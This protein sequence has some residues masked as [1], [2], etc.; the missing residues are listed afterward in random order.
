MGVLR[1]QRHDFDRILSPIAGRNAWT[2]N[3]GAYIKSMLSLPNS[4]KNHNVVLRFRLATDCAVAGTGWYIDSIDINRAAD[5]TPT[6]TATAAGIMIS[7]NVSYCSNPVPGPVPGVTLTITGT[8][9]RVTDSSGNYSFL[10]PP[11]ANITVTPSK[12]PLV[13]GGPGSSGI[14]TADVIAIQKHYL[15][16]TAL[17]GCRLTAADCAAPAGIN[18]VD[19]LA[20]QKFFLQ[21]NGTGNVGQ[22][23]FTPASRFY[24]NVTVNQTNQNYDT[25]VLGDVTAPYVH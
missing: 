8:S 21:L 22:Y 2:G 19:T 9:P 13:P 7:G 15:G 4:A 24:T 16:I 20:V 6:A 10:V 12:A 1:L 3:S 11:G 17:T 25:L 5:P 18:T 14:G 23:Q